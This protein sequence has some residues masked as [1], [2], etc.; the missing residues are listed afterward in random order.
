M[1]GIISDIGNKRDNNQDYVGYYNDK[2]K[3]VYVVADGMGGHNAGEVA[4]KLAVESILEYIKD[5]NNISNPEKVIEEAIKHANDRI[6]HLSS[7]KDAY[8]GM[9]T[10][11]TTCLLFKGR[12]IMANV[13]DSRGYIVKK[14]KLN[15]VTK[16]HSLVQQL[17]D[18]GAISNEQAINH[19]NRNIIT[20]ALGIKYSVKVDI[21]NLSLKGID[22]VL[23]CTDGLTKELTDVEIQ[24][25]ISAHSENNTI[26]RV[27]IDECKKKEASDNISVIV[28]E[29]ECK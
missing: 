17:V 21:F 28:F 16:D 4:S 26:C 8:A 23:L 6:F 9:G 13:G 3:N 20:R 24:R 11:V 15:K 29:G 7:N 14:G 1:L 19:P 5:S 18:N 25:V 10:T 22:K 27:L 12:L 2:E